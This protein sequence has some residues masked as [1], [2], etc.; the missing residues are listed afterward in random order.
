M[1]SLKEVVRWWILGGFLTS[2]LGCC[3]K[4]FECALQVLVHF[5]HRRDVATAVAV[6]GSRPHSHQL[7][8][9][10]PLVAL[11]HELVGAADQVQIVLRVKLCLGPPAI[12][13][14][15]TVSPPKM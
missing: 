13:T 10:H 3:F 15:H 14:L 2:G 1:S 5:H 7:V 6:V 8:V 12:L 11:H 9:E 4:D